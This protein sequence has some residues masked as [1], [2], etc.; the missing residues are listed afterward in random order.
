MR[1][2]VRI[3]LTARSVSKYALKMHIIFPRRIHGLS[4]LFPQAMRI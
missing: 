2:V 1:I 3:S 4:P